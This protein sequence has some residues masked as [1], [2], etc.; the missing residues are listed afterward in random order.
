MAGVFENC[1][2]I[3]CRHFVGRHPSHGGVSRMR[4]NVLLSGGAGTRLAVELP[5]TIG[6]EETSLALKERVIP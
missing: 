6:G 1:C 5:R 2:R 3:T 4:S